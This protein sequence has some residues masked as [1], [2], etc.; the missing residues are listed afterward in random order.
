MDVVEM[1]VVLVWDETLYSWDWWMTWYGSTWK[2]NG[3]LVT[4]VDTRF[5]CM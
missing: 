4:N 2:M 3:N 1:A 5:E